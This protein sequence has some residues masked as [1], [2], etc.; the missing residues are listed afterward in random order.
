M[1]GVIFPAEYAPALAQV[2]AAT[3]GKAVRIKDLKMAHDPEKLELAFALWAEGFVCVRRGEKGAG[4]KAAA[5][6]G[7]A[8][9]TKANNASK[10][11]GEP[12]AKKAKH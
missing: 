9:G 5:S 7:K 8:D 2:L 4:D 3:G 10:S 6:G 11:G 12:A 1:P